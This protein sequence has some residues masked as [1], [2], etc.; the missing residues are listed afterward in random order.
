MFMEQS[1][2]MGRTIFNLSKNRFKNRLV[3]MLQPILVFALRH[4]R[5]NTVIR[6]SGNRSDGSS[7]P[8]AWPVH[9]R[10]YGRRSN[11]RNNHAYHQFV[12]VKFRFGH[13]FHA[14]LG[15]RNKLDGSSSSI[16]QCVHADLRLEHFCL[17]QKRKLFCARH[18]QTSLVA[19]L[20]SY[21]V[22][23]SSIL[24]FCMV[25][26]SKGARRTRGIKCGRLV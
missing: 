2:Q 7:I 15:R 10:N 13:G 11:R 12:F 19:K 1:W 9:N 5:G 24:S 26:P 25:A 17:C 18:K 14:L 22:R 6:I 21:F 23:R 20:S 3:S 4:L 8:P 16:E